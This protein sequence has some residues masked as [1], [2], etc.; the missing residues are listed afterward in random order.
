MKTTIA[1]S[2]LLVGCMKPPSLQNAEPSAITQLGLFNRVS[3]TS[4]PSTRGDE[5]RRS[6]A[7]VTIGKKNE[8]LMDD[9]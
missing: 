6:G 7:D 2:L 3:G 1:I 4:Q 9:H 5:G 8:P